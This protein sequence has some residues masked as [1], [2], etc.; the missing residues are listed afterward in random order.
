MEGEGGRF[1]RTHTVPMPTVESLA[2]L[3]AYLAK[4]D[5]KDDHRRVGQRTSLVGDDFTA[6]QDFCGRC[7]PSRS[8]PGSACDPGSIGTPG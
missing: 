8:R 7:R 2:E 1:R 5:V 6:E 3:N 4:C